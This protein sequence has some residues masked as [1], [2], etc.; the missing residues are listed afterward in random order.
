VN[1]IHISGELKAEEVKKGIF[2]VLLHVNRVPPHI[3]ML[4]DNVYHSLSIKGQELNVSG[5][6]LLKNISLRKIPSV[7]ME[8]RK[9]P[10]FSNVHLAEA[11]AEQVKQFDKVNIAGNTCLSPVR[12]FFSEFYALDSSKIELVF[13]LLEQLG[14][15]HFGARALGAHLDATKQNIFYLQPYKRQDLYKQIEEELSRLKK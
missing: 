15:N 7:F 2:L 14:K 11:F 4:I 12:L 9:H 5:D 3:G 13:D 6:A 10:V 8:I 1:E